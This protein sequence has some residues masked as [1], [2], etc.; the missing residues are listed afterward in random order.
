R[1]PRASSIPATWNGMCSNRC[2]SQG[3]SQRP[4]TPSFA[5]QPATMTVIDRLGQS[6]RRGG[7]CAVTCP[8]DRSPD[9][10][11]GFSWEANGTTC[12]CAGEPDPWAHP[13]SWRRRLDSLTR[14]LRE[15]REG[16]LRSAR[17]IAGI[18]LVDT[19]AATVRHVE[20]C[21]RR[22]GRLGASIDDVLLVLGML[23]EDL[24]GGVGVNAALAAT[25]RLAVD[26]DLTRLHDHHHY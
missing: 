5:C 7:T 15:I 17:A 9:V 1:T 12:G 10:S 13:Q 21:G 2:S 25:D 19:I 26:R 16:R 8:M 22:D 23:K 18:G 20:K 6:S 11:H 3:A 4:S 24:P 14:S